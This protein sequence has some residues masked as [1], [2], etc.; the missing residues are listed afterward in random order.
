MK[1]KNLFF[2]GV[3]IVAIAATILIV[4]PTSH[5]TN[6][7]VGV[8]KEP[9]SKMIN[10]GPLKNK[11]KIIIPF[12]II[13]DSINK[14]VVLKKFIIEGSSKEVNEMYQFIKDNMDLKCNIVTTR[15]NSEYEKI[16][17]VIIK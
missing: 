8:F 15:S 13:Q 17:E 3:F 6:T 7:Y 5:K 11:E 2:I 9:S 4:F 1:T 14:K 12:M 16:L 10:S